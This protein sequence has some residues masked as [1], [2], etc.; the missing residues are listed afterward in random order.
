MNLLD[1]PAMIDAIKR[2]FPNHAIF[3]YPDASGASRKSQKASTSDLALL[4]QAGFTVLA[5]PANP[6]VKDRVLSLNIMLAGCSRGKLFVNDTS[7]PMFA[8]ALEKQAYDEHGEPDKQSGF[9]HA[10]DAGG[11]FVC[12]RFPVLDGRVIKAKMGGV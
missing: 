11:Y 1:T 5:N 9:D 10:N 7:C 12:Y 6:A 8:E 2:R 4:Q 3:V